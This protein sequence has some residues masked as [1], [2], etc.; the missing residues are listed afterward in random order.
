MKK[1]QVGILGLVATLA[2]AVVYSGCSSD[3]TEANTTLAIECFAG[4]TGSTTTPG[5][6]VVGRVGAIVTSAAGQFPG[7][8]N[9]VTVE[10]FGGDLSGGTVQDPVTA[11][12]LPNNFLTQTNDNGE[13]Q[14][15]INCPA[16]AAAGTTECKLVFS[17]GANTCSS[18]M[19]TTLDAT[20]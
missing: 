19:T 7:P 13:I 11:A 14:L 8:Q 17:L 18:A 6:G 15:D 3:F 12:T 5:E 4:S 1:A 2:A 9:G 20:T 10:I 16:P